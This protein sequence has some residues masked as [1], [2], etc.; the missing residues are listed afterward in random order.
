[1]SGVIYPNIVTLREHFRCRPEIIEFCNRYVYN[2]QIIPLK[3]AT[4]DR[5]GPAVEVQYVEDQ[6]EDPKKA[7]IVDKVLKLILDLITDYESGH[8]PELPTIGVLTLDASHEAHRELLIKKLT[9]HPQIRK[10]E[11]ELNILVGT[12]RKFQGDERDVMILT[13]SAHHKIDKQGRMRPPRAV[14]GEE[15][16][17]IYNVAASRAREKSILLHSIHPDAVALMN[18]ECLRSK[19]IHYYEDHQTEDR[20]RIDINAL[21]TKA[22]M[23]SPLSKVVCDGLIHMGWANHLQTNLKIGPYRIDL[24]IIKD[25]RKLAIMCDDKVMDS[26]KEAIRQQLVLERAGW[27]FFRVQP[28]SWIHDKAGVMEGI[29]TFLNSFVEEEKE[30]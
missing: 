8:L 24:A 12:S 28:L 26:A 14:M 16:L 10:Y 4:D 20:G 27:Q 19:L 7:R 23:C 18:P 2:N 30:E 13:I 21:K 25:G 15:M 29:S 3:T 17:R 11:D 9:A 6:G 5:Y 22:E 1:L